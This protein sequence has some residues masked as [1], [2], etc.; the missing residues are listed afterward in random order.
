M[1]RVKRQ[2]AAR[3]PGGNEADGPLS[4]R[5][6]PPDSVA[7]EERAEPLYVLR[8]LHRLSHGLDEMR[9][10]MELAADEADH[11][12][13]VVRVEPVARETDVV[14]EVR[15]AIGAAD[16]CMLPQGGSLLLRVETCERA[17]TPQ[18]IPDGPGPCRIEHRAPRSVE[19]PIVEIRLEPGGVRTAEHHHL[20]SA[21]QIGEWFSG[22]EV[23]ETRHE[24]RGVLGKRQEADS[25]RIAEVGIEDGIDTSGLERGDERLRIPAARVDEKL[26][27][28]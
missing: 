20:G 13:V 5:W 23:A 19:Q 18:W 3:E 24:E 12:I 25:L 15:V 17:D 8:G 11:K 16:R 1:R 28:Q 26:H 27:E 4:A 22:Q 9:Q 10:R 14:R 21:R 6:P 7:D 2:G